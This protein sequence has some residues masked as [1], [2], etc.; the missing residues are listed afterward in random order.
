MRGHAFQTSEGMAQGIPH[1]TPRTENLIMPRARTPMVSHNLPAP[2]LVVHTG[3]TRGCR[4]TRR[5]ASSCLTLRAL[6]YGTLE[7]GLLMARVYDTKVDTILMK[8][9]SFGKFG[10]KSP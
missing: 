10:T 5:G 6:P 1:V 4:A 9:K 8:P 3:A 2:A 7:E